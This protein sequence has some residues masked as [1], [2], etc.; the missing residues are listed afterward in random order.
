[1]LT[2]Q[3]VYSDGVLSLQCV[4]TVCSNSVLR[5]CTHSVF[6]APFGQARPILD[7]MGP[8]GQA[9]PIMDTMGPLGQAR[10]IMD[11]MGPLG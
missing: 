2:A 7:T 8:L 4:Q 9:R 5:H 11:T 6:A 3:T 10:P 1:V